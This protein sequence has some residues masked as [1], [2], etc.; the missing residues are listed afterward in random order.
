MTLHPV[1]KNPANPKD[2]VDAAEFLDDLLRMGEEL[3]EIGSMI[4]ELAV[5]C[6]RAFATWAQLRGVMLPP[7]LLTA[8]AGCFVEFIYIE[9]WKPH[10]SMKKTT[11]PLIR[12][13]LASFGEELI[14]DTDGPASP[15]DTLALFFRF[16][17]DIGYPVDLQRLNRAVTALRRERKSRMIVPTAGIA[18]LQIH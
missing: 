12:E 7:P 16:L 1:K 2:I 4:N 5:Q 17:D 6:G 8:F 18:P 13:F 10:Q 11:K 15:Y 9:K 14:Q 3:W